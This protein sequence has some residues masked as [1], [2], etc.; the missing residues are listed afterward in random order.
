MEEIIHWYFHPLHPQA[1][2]AFPNQ[3][4]TLKLVPLWVICVSLVDGPAGVNLFLHAPC[5]DTK[6]R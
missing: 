5:R 3:N 1:H 6:S 2:I 4:K